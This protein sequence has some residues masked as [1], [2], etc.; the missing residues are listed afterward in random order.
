MSDVL[1]I[2]DVSTEAIEVVTEGPQG[3]PGTGGGGGGS[4]TVTS[5]ALASTDLSISG[6]PITTSGT[7]TAN[8]AANAVTLDK[9]QT[10]SS[11]HLLGRHGSGN[12][13]VQQVGIGTGLAVQGS[14]MAV[15]YGTIAGTA[16]Q[17]NDDRI[18]QIRSGSIDTTN[19][20]GY[21]EL[22]APATSTVLE[23][24]ATAQRSIQFPDAGGIVALT[25][26][27]VDNAAGLWDSVNSQQLL[28]VG[29]GELIFNKVATPNVYALISPN[30]LTGARTITLPDAS[31]T[32]ALAAQATDYEVTDATKGVI[33]KSPNGSRWRVT[34]NDAGQLLRTALAMLML[35]AG[36]H[37]QSLDVIANTNGVLIA[38]TNFLATNR[39]VTAN[40]NNRITNTL[41]LA[42]APVSPTNSDIYIATNTVRFRD[43]TNGE[44]ILLNNLDNLA[45]LGSVT[46]AR[47]NIFGV[48]NVP[49]Y[50]NTNN[51]ITNSISSGAAAN[52]AALL[53]DGAGSSA[54]ALL[55][56]T[57][58]QNI[59]VL[60]PTDNT[61]N[62]TTAA[63]NVAGLSFT[64]SANKTYLIFAQIQMNLPAASGGYVLDA[65]CP[66]IDNYG[67]TT[68]I[69]SIAAHTS[70]SLIAQNFNSSTNARI[71]RATAATVSAVSGAHT[72]LAVSLLRFSTNGTVQF[73]WA[74][75]ATNANSSVLNTNTTITIIPL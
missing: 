14:D 55:A 27:V 32:V 41:S 65:S 73:T 8:I 58:L 75:A 20:N 33:M 64:A 17:G 63:T 26:T 16:C 53:A 22:G 61:T 47:S 39:I 9:L 5:V 57:N 6:S 13:G 30:S 40:S 11:G 50:A 7:I 66:S 23:G 31:G 52:N 42:A 67:A 28:A 38:P 56:I 4:G 59:Q 37:A 71:A 3:P 43:S 70:S 62:G 54:F 60:S 29:D 51:R 45:S 21:L 44:R 69:S 19:G 49:V 35:V 18:A 68:G 25:D 46:T 34:I 48:T 36:A 74:M 24:T 72:T 15:T 2:Y 10:I 12:G 1:E